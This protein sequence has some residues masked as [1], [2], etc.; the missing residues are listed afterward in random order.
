MELRLRIHNALNTTYTLQ[1]NQPVP[2][3][4]GTL[5]LRITL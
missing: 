1:N 2:P 3:R 5:S 4:H